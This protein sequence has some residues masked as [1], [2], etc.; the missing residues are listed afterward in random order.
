MPGT[1]AGTSPLDALMDEEHVRATPRR[2]RTHRPISSYLPA[3]Y[4][5]K[6]PV[7]VLLAAFLTGFAVTNHLINPMSAWAAIAIVV[8]VAAWIGLY[9]LHHALAYAVSILLAFVVAYLFYVYHSQLGFHTLVAAV[10]YCLIVALAY[11]SGKIRR[12]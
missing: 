8:F 1:G 5:I 7:C 10:I 6:A 11:V 2:V 9:R 3:N 4:L 12:H